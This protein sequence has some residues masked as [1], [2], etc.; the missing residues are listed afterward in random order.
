MTEKKEKEAKKTTA[1]KKV[2]VPPKTKAKTLAKEKVYPAS[3]IAKLLGIS[4]FA[5]HVMK[6]E[7]GITDGS[8]LTIAEFR[9]LQEQIIGR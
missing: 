2:V 6:K 3:E 4:Q 8:L 1:K 9:I 5:F 7:A